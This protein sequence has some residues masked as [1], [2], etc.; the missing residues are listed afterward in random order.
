M[1]ISRYWSSIRPE[2]ARKIIRG[3]STAAALAEIRNFNV[4]NK[5]YVRYYCVNPPSHLLILIGIV[6]L[7]L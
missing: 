7:L 6:L 2:T 1:L 3:L 4:P 5:N